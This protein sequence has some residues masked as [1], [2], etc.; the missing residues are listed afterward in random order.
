MKLSKSLTTLLLLTLAL[1]NFTKTQ[2]A[3]KNI[4]IAP[5]TEVLSE[6]QEKTNRLF[7]DTVYG[8]S[9]GLYCCRTAYSSGGPNYGCAICNTGC[10][11]V[12]NGGNHFKCLKCDST[13][14]NC[15]TGTGYCKTC[16][17]S[18]YYPIYNSR[19]CGQCTSNCL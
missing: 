4:I 10:Y 5:K 3:T 12:G 2:E 11:K 13:C 16:R 18:N 9:R 17:Y 19:S 15:E 14:S 1:A 8:Q 6:E 7:R